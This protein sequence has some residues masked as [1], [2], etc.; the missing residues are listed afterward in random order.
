MTRRIRHSRN[1]GG[2]FWL[3]PLPGGLGMNIGRG[4]SGFVSVRSWEWAKYDHADHME[5]ENRWATMNLSR[6]PQAAEPFA[7]AWDTWQHARFL[8]RFGDPQ[9]RPYPSPLRHAAQEYRAARRLR[10]FRER[11]AA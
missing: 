4:Y 3:L 9:G 5:E 1:E 7:L 8:V 10:R 11:L 2:S 6:G